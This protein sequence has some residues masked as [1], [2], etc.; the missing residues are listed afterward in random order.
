MRRFITASLAATL[1]VIAII[2]LMGC[3]SQGSAG[4]ATVTAVS[5]E[6]GSGTRSS[7]V[8]LFGIQGTNSNGKTIDITTAY[9][10]VTNSTEVMITT[11][12]GNKYAI[13]YIS[14]GSLNSMVKA[15]KVDGAE[16]TVANVKNGTYKIV[17]PFIVVTTA[18]LSALGQDF[19]NYI[20][21]AEGQAV[22]LN[23]GYVTVNDAAPAYS[24]RNQSGTL[25]VAG[26]SSVT[27][28]MEKLAEAYEAANPLVDVQIQESDSSTGIAGVTQGICDVGMSSRTL[29]DSE[30]AQGLTPTVIARDGICV[31]VNNANAL[32]SI[33]SDSVK[34]LYTGAITT[35]GNVG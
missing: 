14:L 29:K 9:A 12:A 20:M 18:S 1:V 8:Q 35:W 19:L 23:T 22:I 5:R 3:G 26:S 25:V 32:D 24:G 11:V 16:P 7:F 28:V 4:N 30:L 15:L 34:D 13:G 17:R 27:P 10:E 31:I 2:G 21:S 6:D 33:T